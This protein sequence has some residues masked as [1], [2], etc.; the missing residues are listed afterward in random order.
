MKTFKE[1]FTLGVSKP[2]KSDVQKYLDRLGSA[3][4][5]LSIPDIIKKIED[6]FKTI[7]NLKIDRSARKVLSFEEFEPEINE[8][9]KDYPGKGWV[10]GTKDAPKIN[11]KDIVWRSKVHHWDNTV[12]SD[13]TRM[14]IT[15][16]G[17]GKDKFQMWAVSDKSGDVV[18][19]FGDKP[20]L[21][22]AKEFAS[23]R[24]WQEK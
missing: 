24:K 1:F 6:Y 20:T 10:H 19:H 17:K 2:S 21:D 23:I 9:Y 15:N 13:D 11:P 18:F 16:T 14:I 22:T 8:V 4:R 5:L 7:K 12:R 3:R